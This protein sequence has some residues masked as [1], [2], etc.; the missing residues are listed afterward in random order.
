MPSLSAVDSRFTVKFAIL[1]GGSGT[2]SGV[3]NEPGQGEVPSFQFNL[4]RRLLRVQP[5]LPLKAGMV[6]KD[7]DGTV[8]M[9]GEHGASEVSGRTLFRNFR[10]FEATAQFAWQ[11]RGKAIDPV[12]TLEKDTGLK[13]QPPIWGTYEPESREA[14]DRGMRSNFETGRFITTTP[15][16]R[17]DMIDGRKVARVDRQLGIYICMLG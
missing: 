12:T 8:F 17:D 4:P 16:E 13:D 1:V 15:V 6:I 7:P 11:K 14:F 10:M 5:G 9:L 3:I 2:F